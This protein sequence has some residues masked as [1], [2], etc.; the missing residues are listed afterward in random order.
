MDYAIGWD[1]SGVYEIYNLITNQ[2]YIGSTGRSFNCRKHEHWRR[3]RRNRHDNKHLQRAW[4]K[5]GE[6]NFL[7]HPLIICLENDII[8]LE[9]LL[10]DKLQPAYNI[11]PC[12]ENPNLGI[13][14]SEET[15]DKIRQRLYGNKNTLGYKQTDNHIQKRSVA[16]KWLGLIDP[17]GRIY[18][19]IRNLPKFCEQHNLVYSSI[20]NVL[21]GRRS[22]CHG[23]RCY[24]GLL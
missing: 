9:Q 1:Q 6:Q 17:S 8:K 16:K 19:P 7:F 23:W 15:K 4:N 22:S 18:A 12:I 21:K 5:Y 20:F 13:K 3:L 2:R 14:R 11:S 24:N 10:I